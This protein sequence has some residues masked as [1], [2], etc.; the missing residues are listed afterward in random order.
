M[1]HL[2]NR[3]RAFVILS[4]QHQVSGDFAQLD[5]STLQLS[6]LARDGRGDNERGRW[7]DVQRGKWGEVQRGRWGE[8]ER[9]IWGEAVWV[10]SGE[11]ER[12]RC[13]KVERVFG[14]V[15]REMPV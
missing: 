8:V 14:E 5:I 13:G 6:L 1:R 4:A 15:E 12:G 2:E 7:G 10:R 11:V 9:G 3:M